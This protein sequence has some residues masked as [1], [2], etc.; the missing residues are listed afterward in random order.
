M[1]LS[2][3]ACYSQALQ[4]SGEDNVRRITVGYSTTLYHLHRSFSVEWCKTKITFGELGNRKRSQP[5][6]RYCSDIC[7]EGMRKT[8]EHLSQSR[9]LNR[10]L[11]VALPL[12][13]WIRNGESNLAYAV[14]T[15]R[16]PSGGGLHTR[17]ERT[18]S[19]GNVGAVATVRSRA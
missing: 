11:P 16:V 14:F 12:G 5:I 9:E 8:R 17:F 13:V 10:V 15:V 19:P 6:S 18:C 2:Q 7:L 1:S 3:H 4:E